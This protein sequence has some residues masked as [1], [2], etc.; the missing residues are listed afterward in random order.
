MTT[1]EMIINWAENDLPAW[2]SDAVRRL[3]SLDSLSDDDRNDILRMMKA[4]AGLNDGKTSVPI[5]TPVS[6]GAVS[7]APKAKNVVTLKAIE[8]LKRVNAIPDG[9][10]LCFGHQ[11]LTAVYGENGAG[12]SGYARVLKRACRARDTSERLLPNIFAAAAVAPAEASFK[13]SIDGAPDQSIQWKDEQTA[14][15]VLTNI[16]VFDSK[17]ARIIVDEK[18]QA[19]YL[20]YGADV[21]ESLV[22]LLDWLRQQLNEE[23]PKPEALKFD[24]MPTTTSAGTLLATLAHDTDRK[25]LEDMAQWSD[26]DEKRLR[27]LTKQLADLEVNDPVKKARTT[28]G[29][30]ERIIKLRDV[31]KQNDDSLS[32]TSFATAVALVKN[33]DE[34]KKALDAAS[35]LTL[36]NEPL[37]RAGE[38]AWQ[39]LYNAAKEYATTLAYPGRPFPFTE[40]GSRCVLCMQ[41]LSDEGKDRFI[42]FKRFMEQETKKKHETASKAVEQAVTQLKQ[43]RTPLPEQYQGIV[44]DIRNLD[45]ELADTVCD[46]F[47]SMVLRAEAISRILAGDQEGSVQVA[48][49]TPQCTLS[50]LAEKLEKE[51][52]ELDNATKPEGLEKLASEKAERTA[53]KRFAAEKEKIFRLFEQLRLVHKYDQ[54]I[55]STDTG[56]VTRKGKAVISSALTSPLRQAVSV[57]LKAL[58]AASL[59]LSVKPSASKGETL[60]QLELEGA[61]NLGKTH[62]TDILSEGEQRVVAIAGFLAELVLAKHT[63]PIV[64][65]DPV[66]SL[67]HV[68]REKIAARLVRESEMRQVIVFTHD[69][70]F[71]LALR[72]KA[73]EGSS[74]Y[75]VPQTVSRR[76]GVIG[77]CDSSLP[78]HAMPV[79]D[80]LIA[81]RRKLDV[82]RSFHSND[83]QKYN[84]ESAM[85]YAL[86]RETWEATIEEVVLYKTVVR[87]GNEVQTQRLKSVGVTTE[88]Y[89]KIDLGMSRCSTW[90]FGH[91]KSK[92]LA[93]NR[94]NPV[95]IE[96]DINEL[97]MFIK[98]A[99]K[100]AEILRKERDAA[101]EPQTPSVG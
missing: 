91:D 56:A 75:F 35:Q 69:I 55:A 20:P 51:A 26:D 73:G 42:R 48:K 80:R 79:K 58:G 21:F 78:W 52:I 60:H 62:L 1:L 13:I 94:P 5:P 45:E 25:L 101:L 81:L 24:D 34:A 97:A 93:V 32:D 83:V 61:Q 36:E 39:S 38:T 7:G 8:N 17:C 72:E 4:G 54:C 88:Q 41:T 6:A 77:T 16:A 74:T 70:A 43:V 98:D 82:V 59:P 29:L 2:Q 86:L 3:L 37:P 85:I 12:K 66:T 14:D 18:N 23:K 49:P 96:Q 64:F 92:D 19:H 31:V 11:G 33:C 99:N 89:K 76:N 50:R 28:R 15:S 27:E 9:A 57:E 65:D 10:S 68:Y 95:D 100:A 90:M 30:K 22:Q 63:S 84:V 87:H 67:D 71:L 47:P 44:G 40:N 46:Y 53:R